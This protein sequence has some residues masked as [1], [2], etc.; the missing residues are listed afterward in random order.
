[1]TKVKDLLNERFKTVSTLG[2]K[3]LTETSSNTELETQIETLTQKNNILNMKTPLKNGL[4]QLKEEGWL[5]ESDYQ[6]INTTIN[7]ERSP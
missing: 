6:I 1:M 4:L 3:L 5:S 2:E 7:T